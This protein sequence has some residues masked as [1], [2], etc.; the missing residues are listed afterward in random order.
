MQHLDDDTDDVT[1]GANGF[2]FVTAANGTVTIATTVTTGRHTKY[3]HILPIIKINTCPPPMELLLVSHQIKNEAYSGIY[4]KMMLEIDASKGFRHVE[5]FL[6]I[7]ETL[8]TPFSPL[9]HIRNAAVTFVWDTQWYQ[10]HSHDPQAEFC[11]EVLRLRAN[12][13]HQLVTVSNLTKITINWHDSEDSGDSLAMRSL[14]LEP[15]D[16][17]LLNVHREPIDINI[18]NHFEQQG[19]GHKPSGLVSAMRR[20]FDEI[21]TG[22][23]FC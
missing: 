13:V 2:Q 4:N 6:T 21:L 22:K 10:A 11:N 8:K 1:D 19:T 23:E 18:I 14:V 17:I 7:L 9:H 3:R 12:L 16:D 5:F 20:E 15:F